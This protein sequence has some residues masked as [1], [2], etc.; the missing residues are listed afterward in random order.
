MQKRKALDVE[1]IENL[2]YKKKLGWRVIADFLQCNIKTI[3]RFS[4]AHGINKLKTAHR[5]SYPENN[6]A[7]IIAR[8]HGFMNI[9]Q[10]VNDL[11]WSG[12]TIEQIAKITGLHYTNVQRYQ[13]QNVKG[14]IHIYTEKKKKSDLKNL[15]KARAIS[16]K[17]IDEGSHI[18]QRMYNKQ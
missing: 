18:W 14:E 11:R 4:V 1:E 12:K 8:R 10:M 9:R 5:G 7:N 15:E 13:N 16:Q 17:K 3:I 2:R 6:K